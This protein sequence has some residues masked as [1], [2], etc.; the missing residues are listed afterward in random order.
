VHRDVPRI[1]RGACAASRACAA[2]PARRR[3]LALALVLA[4]AAGPACRRDAAPPPVPAPKLEAEFLALGGIPVHVRAWD[5]DPQVFGRVVEEYRAEVERQESILSV[6]R[7]GSTLSRLNRAGG[8][9]VAVAGDT[10]RLLRR[11]AECAAETGG[12]FDPTVGPLL[13]AWKEAARTGV[14]P[15]AARL[16]EALAGVGAQRVHVEGDER[17]GGTVRLD[18][19]TTL[20]L[21]GIAKGWFAD[22][23]LARLRAAGI[24]RGLVELGGDLALYDDRP[25]PEP[26]RIGV[27]DPDDPDGL[28]GRL[29]V[30]RGSV[31]TSGDYE[32]GYDVGGRRYN[33]IVDPRTG[34]PVAGLRAVTLWTLDGA[35]ADALATAV[36][37]LGEREG[38]AFVRRTPGVEAILVAA[39]P[40]APR[41]VR[42]R[43]TPGW[44]GRFEAH[45]AWRASLDPSP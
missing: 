8:A 15:S 2:R 43:V 23:G 16:A 17:A 32:R 31:V 35:R 29:R 14:E 6:H 20:D 12:A 5:A 33:H 36:M 19:P 18:P 1:A 27:R 34:R 24:R 10:L 38:W 22:L 21:G 7:A 42:I 13:D 11:A 44:Q 37:V 25:R 4:A 30:E 26:F 40:S 41:G 3:F 28:L 45:P 39:D 9:P